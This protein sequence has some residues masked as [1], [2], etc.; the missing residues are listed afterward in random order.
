[1]RSSVRRLEETYADRV[2]FHIL[3]V[4]LIATRE[5]AQQYRVSAIPMIVLLDADGNLVQQF[6]GFQSEEQLIAAV[7]ALLQ[8]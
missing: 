5:L 4:D 8:R 7:E 2:D 6:I 1:M 3:N